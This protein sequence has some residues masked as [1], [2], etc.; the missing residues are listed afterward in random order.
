MTR[1]IPTALTSR[2]QELLEAIIEEYTR[3]CTPVGSKLLAERAGYA[4]SPATIRNDLAVLEESGMLTH[5]H[6][7]AG[8][9]PTDAGYQYYV[10]HQRRDYRLTQRDRQRLRPGVAQSRRDQIKSIAKQLAELGNSC[11]VVGFAASDVYYTG[12]ANL[13]A[14]PEF[15]DY[16]FS[17]S[18]SQVIDHLDESLRNIFSQVSDATE[19]QIFIGH[20]NPF[21]SDCGTLLVG[22]P[23]WQHVAG[24]LGLLGPVRM[25]YRRNRALLAYAQQLLAVEVRPDVLTGEIVGP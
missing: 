13:F 6:T 4:V 11:A 23:G 9:V 8:R 1:Q 22:F 3:S 25:D 7:S 24:V 2:Q 15:E 18:I 14:Q 17:C 5:P 21:A 16:D 10:D 20:R 12:L 19:V